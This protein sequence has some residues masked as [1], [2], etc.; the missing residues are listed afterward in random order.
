M[1]WAG[2]CRWPE[3]PQTLPE[4]LP[5][6]GCFLWQRAQA[7]KQEAA[8]MGAVGGLQ[9]GP[10]A[11]E[12]HVWLSNPFSIKIWGLWSRERGEAR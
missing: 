11:R 9:E 5:L 8:A 4:G 6:P 3:P 2:W 12:F 10:G 7:A 1:P